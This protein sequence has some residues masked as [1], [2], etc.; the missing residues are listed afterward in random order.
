MHATTDE[1]RRVGDD[2]MTA[3]FLFLLGRLFCTFFDWIA[4]DFLWRGE[5]RGDDSVVAALFVGD[6]RPSSTIGG[7]EADAPI[8]GCCCC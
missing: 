7:E 8:G 3:V 5:Y 2:L 6:S 1:S 4:C